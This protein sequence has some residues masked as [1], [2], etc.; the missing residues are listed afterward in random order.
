MT[1][2]RIN[3]YGGPGTG[4]STMAAG[5]YYE[6]KMHSNSNNHVKQY[7]LVRE[8]VKT[9][10]WEGRK[11]TGFDQF[12]IFSKQ[13][14]S[15]E[16]CL[17]NGVDVIITDSPL[18]LSYMY[19]VAY[20]LDCRSELKQAALAF[21]AKY[22]ALHV[23]LVRDHDKPYNGKGRFQSL[24]EA[25]N[26]DTMARLTL[27]NLEFPYIEVTSFDMP[28]LLNIVKSNLNI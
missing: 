15:E 26:L 24:D 1:I 7:E 16:V 22:P 10:A 4:K 18:P 8:Y 2:R 21:E 5:L 28:S 12:Y 25:I 6:M 17:K 20:N 19:T 9:W 27:K 11:I 3:L 14:R 23:M 13:M